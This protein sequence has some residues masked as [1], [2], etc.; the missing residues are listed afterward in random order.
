MRCENGRTENASTYSLKKIIPVEVRICNLCDGQFHA[1]L[2]IRRA[3]RLHIFHH[4]QFNGGL[5]L[6]NA[7]IGRID[8]SQDRLANSRSNLPTFN[9]GADFARCRRR[10]W[11]LALRNRWH[12]CHVLRAIQTARNC[13]TASAPVISISV[14]RTVSR[15]V[16]PR[17]GGGLPPAQTGEQQV[18]RGLTRKGLRARAGPR[19]LSIL[20]GL[21][22]AVVWSSLIQ[23]IQARQWW[24]VEQLLAR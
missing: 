12:S 22:G 20:R 17:A 19:T 13:R 21:R 10:G 9:I 11:L 4:R 23:G 1:E 15:V 5:R 18:Q 14:R 7:S 24:P 6:F 2:R 8:D 16:V 3:S